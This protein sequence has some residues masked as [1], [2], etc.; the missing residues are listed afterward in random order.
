[1]NVCACACDCVCFRVDLHAHVGHAFMH[2]CMLACT[3]STF[4]S[5]RCLK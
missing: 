2:V 4:I 3:D 1:M 5:P